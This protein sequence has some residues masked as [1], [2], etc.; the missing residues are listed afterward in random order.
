MRFPVPLRHTP[1]FVVHDGLEY[2][3]SRCVE[4][5]AEAYISVETMAGWTR[6]VYGFWTY[7]YPRVI[8]WR[9]VVMS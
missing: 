1:Q 6:K 4:V 9:Q 5:R 3:C 2:A 7:I 8:S